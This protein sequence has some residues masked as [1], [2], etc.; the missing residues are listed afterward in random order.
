M[1]LDETLMRLNGGDGARTRAVA[2]TGGVIEKLLS[3]GIEH[4]VVE[5]RVI[6][7]EDVAFE[8]TESVDDSIDDNLLDDSEGVGFEIDD[9]T[10]D[11]LNDIS[12]GKVTELP[13]LYMQWLCDANMISV[14]SL[15]RIVLTAEAKKWISYSSNPPAV[16]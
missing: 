7:P 13:K 10:W 5:G 2:L 9:S 15:G 3:T 11:L 1:T 4:V 16:S 8:I 14:T 6:V 12:S